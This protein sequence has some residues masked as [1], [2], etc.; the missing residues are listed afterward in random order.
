MALITKTGL[1]VRG[2]L[3]L[4]GMLALAACGPAKTGA[5][6][7]A[8][9]PQLTPESVCLDTARPPLEA[10]D[11]CKQVIVQDPHDQAARHRMAYLR[12]KTGSFAAAR[13]AYQIALSENPADAEA[14][15]GLGLTMEANGEAGGNLQKVKAAAR[16]PN[17][18]GVFRKYG[19]SEPDLLTFDTAPQI[20]KGPPTHVIREMSPSKPLARDFAVDVKCLISTAAALHDC[21]VISPLTPNDADFGEAAKKIVMLTKVKPAMDKGK[22]VADAPIVLSM[23]FTATN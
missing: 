20:L 19:V 6:G 13:Q 10:I 9:A 18:I 15:F 7:S 3:A 5:G 1:G 14:Q 22:P 11:G 8:A 16:D 21:K 12:L 17:V 4:F 23:V 2:R